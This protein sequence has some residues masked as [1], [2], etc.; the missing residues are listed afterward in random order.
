MIRAFQLLR[1]S[2]VYGTSSE[3]EALPVDSFA[4]GEGNTYFKIQ[5]IKNGNLYCY[6]LDYDAH[7][8]NEE[9]LIMNDNIIF[10]RT[11]DDIIMPLINKGFKGRIKS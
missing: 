11:V 4:N 9:R 2:I 6:E 5:F 7:S 8:I 1:D 10:N 3:L